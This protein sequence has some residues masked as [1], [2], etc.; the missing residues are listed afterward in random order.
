MDN[1]SYFIK[2]KAMF[3]SFPTQESVR[4]LEE[5]G[6]RYFIDLTTHE[7]K[8][9]KIVPYDTN[10]VYI[11][12]P[13]ADRHVPVNWQSFAKFILNVCDI[14][15]SCRGGHLVYIGCRGGH[16][17]SGLV[18]AAILCHLYGMTPEKSLEY[19][20][21]CH[22][23]RKTM[24]ERWRKIGAP[25]TY[26]QKKFIYKFFLPLRFY[27]TYKHANTLGFS[28]FSQHSV[29]VP[30]IGTFSTSEAAFQAHKNLDNIEYVKDQLNTNT[31]VTA[32]YLGNK[33]KIREDWDSVKV[34][35]MEHIIQLKFDQNEEIRKNLLNTG[36]R[37]IVEHVKDDDFWGD[38]GDGTGQNMLGKILTKI[39]NKYYETLEF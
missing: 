37:P 18:T 5:Q 14:I 30:G 16:G 38:N 36:L 22:S 35:I 34:G 4:E 8:E 7:E 39:R 15:K 11:N 2:D 1:C 3:G 32:R 10:Y 31:A 26:S 27:R 29:N 21:H 17:R 12:Y 6:V 25:Q 33:I 13:I 20:T 28:N 24:K 9:T 23:K 19:T